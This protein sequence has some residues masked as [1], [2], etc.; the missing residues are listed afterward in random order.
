MSKISAATAA[1]EL[2]K[3]VLII[4]ANT[5]CRMVSVGKS[6]IVKQYQEYQHRGTPQQQEAIKLFRE[7]TLKGIAMAKPG[8]KSAVGKIGEAKQKVEQ[9]A[10][11]KSPSDKPK[12]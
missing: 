10:A 5:T 3:M 8:L 11:E 9:K 6:E 2:T 1:L 12:K 7:M 4:A